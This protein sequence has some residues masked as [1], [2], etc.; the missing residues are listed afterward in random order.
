MNV[1]SVTRY[2]MDES[3]VREI[4]KSEGKIRVIQR[5]PT[6]TKKCFTIRDIKLE[7]TERAL[8]VWF[9]N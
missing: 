6:A 2:G 5:A 4:K 7:E 1:A 3:S 8:N 9:E